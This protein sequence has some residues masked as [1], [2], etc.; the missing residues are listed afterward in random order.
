MRALARRIG[1]SANALYRHFPNKEGLLAALSEAAAEKLAAAVSTA[2]GTAE[3]IV[4]IRAMGVAYVE[5]AINNPPLFRLLFKNAPPGNL[6]V[7]DI[8]SATGAVRILRQQIAERWPEDTDPQQIADAT[9][10]AWSLAHGLAC[11]IL[12]RQIPY[13]LDRIKKTLGP[14]KLPR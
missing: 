3:G 8:D 7:G 9:L 5:F 12:D 14:M 10:R 1:V 2:L 4:G 6:L 13:D 11:L